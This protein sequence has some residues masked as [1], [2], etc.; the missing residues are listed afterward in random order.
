M[1]YASPGAFRQALED[2]LRH[3]NPPEVL[4]RLRKMIA[5]ERF[6]ARLNDE[7]ILKG[8]YALQLRTP[9]ART[10]QDIDLLA[11]TLIADQLFKNLVEQ[12]QQEMGDYF[13]FELNWQAWTKFRATICRRQLR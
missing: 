1:R 8:G 12:L 4:A 5:F 7:W 11:T 6:M 3:E 2:R 10:T 13:T 9:K